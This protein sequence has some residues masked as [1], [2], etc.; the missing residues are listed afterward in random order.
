M[1]TCW[2]DN[3]LDTLKWKWTI[4]L[5]LTSTDSFNFLMWPLEKFKWHLQL[6]LTLVFY[7][8]ALLQKQQIPLHVLILIPTYTVKFHIII[9]VFDITYVTY[10]HKAL[11]LRNQIQSLLSSTRQ[12]NLLFFIIYILTTVL[13]FVYVW[14][15]QQVKEIFEW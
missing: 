15:N 8:T 9:M 10:Y 4:L 13:N 11:E 12:T 3:I 6:W 1:I 5:K 2:N 14:F 7:S